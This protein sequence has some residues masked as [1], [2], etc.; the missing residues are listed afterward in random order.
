V[1]LDPLAPIVGAG[2]VVALLHA[3]LPTHWLPFVLVGRAHAWSARRVLS[4]AALAGAGHVL[5]TLLLGLVL[6]SAGIAVQ[7]RMGALFSRAV[8][9]VILA[10]GLFYLLRYALK[11]GH[12]H[13]D[14]SARLTTRSDAAAVIGLVA[15]LTFSPGEAFLPL[16]VVNVQFGWLGFALLSLVLTI[17]TFVAMLGLTGL[18]LAGADRLRLERLGRYEAAVIGVALC[19]LGLFVALES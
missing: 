9:V 19:G 12:A 2:F 8:G 10:V 1:N 4:V 6:L 16:Y 14:P 15:M 18:C 7:P 3:A 11:P 17:G 5:F 13:A